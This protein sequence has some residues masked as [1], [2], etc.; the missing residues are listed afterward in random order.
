MATQ[1]FLF[2]RTTLNGPAVFVIGPAMGCSRIGPYEGAVALATGAWSTEDIQ[3]V[4]VAPD[5]AD[6]L[7]ALP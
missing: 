1:T 3:L 2:F 7:A 4:V 6:W 5:V